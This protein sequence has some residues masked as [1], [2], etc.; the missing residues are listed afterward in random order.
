MSQGFRYWQ[1][2]DDFYPGSLSKKVNKVS[3]LILIKILPT[4]RM[5]FN[6]KSLLL[7][8]GLWLEHTEPINSN[9]SD[10][11]LSSPLLGVYSHQ[12]SIL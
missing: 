12:A 7:W 8:E 3:I 5:C 11:A 1:F 2:R 10:P 9:I 6:S 4:S